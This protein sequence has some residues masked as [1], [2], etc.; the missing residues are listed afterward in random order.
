MTQ[1]ENK[2]AI[3]NRWIEEM[4]ERLSQS[5]TDSKIEALKRRVEK[6]SDYSRGLAEGCAI[7]D[8]HTLEGLRG[9]RNKMRDLSDTPKT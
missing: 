5:R 3:C 6:D 2:L 1:T 9:L 8:T 4:I 7:A